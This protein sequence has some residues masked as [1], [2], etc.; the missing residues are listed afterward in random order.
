MLRAGLWVWTPVSPKGEAQ[1]GERGRERKVSRGVRGAG[2]CELAVREE[3]DGGDGVEGLEELLL[4]LRMPSKNSLQSLTHVVPLLAFIAL[5]C[6]TLRRSPNIDSFQRSFSPSLPQRWL[7][8]NL[9]RFPPHGPCLA[10][11]A[12]RE[13]MHARLCMVLCQM[14]IEGQAAQDGE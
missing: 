14:A 11:P 10:F 12:P 6:N 3:S 13:R 4:A 1:G 8:S 9:S 2:T 7:L 5:S